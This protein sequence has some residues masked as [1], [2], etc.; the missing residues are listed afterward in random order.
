MIDPDLHRGDIVGQWLG[1]PWCVFGWL[2]ERCDFGDCW[3][4]VS[5]FDGAQDDI[6]GSLLK[7]VLPP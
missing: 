5:S 6:L 1:E 7:M 4:C 3:V 2:V